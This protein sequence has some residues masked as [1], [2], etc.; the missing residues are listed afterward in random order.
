MANAK[1][2]IIVIGSNSFSGGFIIKKLLLKNYKV[3]GISR[4]KLNDE[5]FLPFKYNDPNFIFFKA[6]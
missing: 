3:I 6:D 4:S 1:K 2:K 5:H